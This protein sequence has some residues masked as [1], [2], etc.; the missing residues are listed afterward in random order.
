MARPPTVP[1]PDRSSAAVADVPV[2]PPP[3]VDPA[4]RQDWLA[5]LA[6]VLDLDLLRERL[7]LRRLGLTPLEIAAGIHH[8][9]RTWILSWTGAVIDK[10]EAEIV[11]NA[12]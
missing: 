5:G 4:A 9:Y 11:W 1:P 8:G 6:R 10:F 12:T 7:V 3:P 2:F